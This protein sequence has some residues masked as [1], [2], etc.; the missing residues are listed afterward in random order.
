MVLMSGVT[1]ADAVC[2][3]LGIPPTG[4]GPA[5]F[6]SDT[7]SRLLRGGKPAAPALQPA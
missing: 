2:E 7:G 1:A 5:G 3:D 4:K 6:G